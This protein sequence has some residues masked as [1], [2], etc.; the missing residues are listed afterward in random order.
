MGKKTRRSHDSAYYMSPCTPLEIDEINEISIRPN[1][2]INVKTRLD[3]ASSVAFDIVMG[4]LN[5]ELLTNLRKKET[6]DHLKLH[7]C[8]DTACF[9]EKMAATDRRT[10]AA[11]IRRGFNRLI[12]VNLVYDDRDGLGKWYTHVLSDF[13]WIK[14]TSVIEYDI[15]PVF[16]KAVIESVDTHFTKF[17]WEHSLSLQG[18]YAK[19]LF[20]CLKQYENTGVRY[21]RI[22]DLREILNF[23]QTQDNYAFL[24]AIDKSINE[25]NKRADIITTYRPEY[26]PGQRGKPEITR[27]RFHIRKKKLGETKLPAPREPEGTRVKTVVPAKDVIE[28]AEEPKRL[29][30]PQDIPPEDFL[31]MNDMYEFI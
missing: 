2:I 8:V 31:S 23:P 6:P 28:Q 21:D 17:R 1:E 16:K 26:E 18:K 30:I 7:Y 5:E 12:A 19:A 29:F 15:A 3:F 14:N 27:L 10:N 25:I 22:R 11:M 13:R 4:V 24:L 20:F 9:I